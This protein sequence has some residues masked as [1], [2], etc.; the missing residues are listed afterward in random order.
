MFMA[1]CLSKVTETFFDNFRITYDMSDLKKKN[2]K[3]KLRVWVLGFDKDE[4]KSNL[5]EQF[6]NRLRNAM[7]QTTVVNRVEIDDKSK[8][9]IN[10]VNDIKNTI[11]WR[12]VMKTIDGRK[13]PTEFIEL[14]AQVYVIDDGYRKILPPY[15]AMDSSG[16]R[17]VNYREWKENEWDGQLTMRCYMVTRLVIPG[18]YKMEDFLVNNSENF[19]FEKMFGKNYQSLV[20]YM[21]EHNFH[22]DTGDMYTVN[23]YE[24]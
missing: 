9:I 19:T 23:F 17:E 7:N 6:D 5:E 3:D 20:D 15:L 16:K 8:E 14:Y 12:K 2:W 4:F 13:R 1:T 21:R 22:R 24:V 10:Q 11:G 18:Y